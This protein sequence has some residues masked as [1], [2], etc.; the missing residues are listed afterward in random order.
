MKS[1]EILGIPYL[2]NGSGIHIKK[3][4]RGKFT[5][6]KKRT[7]K[8]TEE[9]THSKNPLTRKRAIFAQNAKKFKHEDGGSVHKPNGHRSILDNG[10]FKTK[11]LKKN[12]PL[13]YYQGGIFTTGALADAAWSFPNQ[14]KY[15]EGNYN[16]VNTKLLSQLKSDSRGHYSDKVKLINHPTHPRRGTFS[17]DGLK[18]YMSNFGMNNP[19]LTLFGTADG[20]Q[21]SQTTMVYKGG[22][23]LPEITVTPTQRYIDNPYDQFKLYLK[24]NHPLTFGDGGM[25]PK[26]Q[27]SGPIFT[28]ETRERMKKSTDEAVDAVKAASKKASDAYSEFSDSPWNT[29]YDV[30]NTGL[31]AAAPFTGGATLVPAMVM[32]IGQG[33]AAANNMAHEGANLNNSL[34]VAGGVL[35]APGKMVVKPMMKMVGKTAKY[36]KRAPLIAKSG[37]GR[38][39]PKPLWQLAKENRKYAP[40]AAYIYGNIGVNNGQL[41]NDLYDNYQT[42]VAP[43]IGYQDK[44][45]QRVTQETNK[46]K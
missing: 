25:I 8:T 36:A 30:V 4:N 39:A 19:N 24:K 23:V 31:Y 21:D 9:L 38:L 15:G 27:W 18:F 16:N 33:L 12:H 29:V 7:G 32:S 1:I 17:Q 41:G 3:E 22:V 46:R 35:A 42:Y 11:D 26:F 37:K 45:A 44:I 6:T 20:N 34:D 13:V 40:Y 14:I 2:A 5:E 43:W 10:W 28:K